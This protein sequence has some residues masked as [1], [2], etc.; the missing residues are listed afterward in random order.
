MGKRN[1]RIA[2]IDL[3]RIRPTHTYSLIE[4]A[5]DTRRSLATV[6]RWI[7]LGLPVITKTNPILVDGQELLQWLIERRAARKR[8]CAPDEIF[9][10]KCRVP[11]RAVIGSVIIKPRNEKLLSIEGECDECGT[12]FRKGGAMADID[13]IEAAWDSYTKNVHYLARYRNP[14]VSKH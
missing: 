9:C 3:R 14:P 1:R 6:R 11:R 10:C 2:K 8:P 5:K 4:I 7:T 13:K 12:G